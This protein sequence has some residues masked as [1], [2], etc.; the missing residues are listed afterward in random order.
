MATAYD[1][2]KFSS[3]CISVTWGHHRASGKFVVASNTWSDDEMV[4]LL[5]IDSVYT[6]LQ[7]L[8]NS[9]QSEQTPVEYTETTLNLIEVLLLY[10]SFHSNER[11][12]TIPF[13]GTYSRLQTPLGRWW[14]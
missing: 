4:L 5:Q 12:V 3:S 6:D 10:V 1:A 14:N 13:S 2:A 8:M 11:S 9:S 7:R